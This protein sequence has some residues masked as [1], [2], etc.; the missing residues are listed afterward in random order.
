MQTLDPGSNTPTP[1]ITYAWGF[2]CAREPRRHGYEGIWMRD[3]REGRAG[4]H[5]PDPTGVKP[6]WVVV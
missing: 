1:P 5:R 4:V 6:A 2:E 3:E